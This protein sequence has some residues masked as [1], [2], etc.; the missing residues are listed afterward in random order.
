VEGLGSFNGRN[1]YGVHSDLRAIGGRSGFCD[2]VGV[3]AKGFDVV[4]KEVRGSG[5]RHKDE[6]GVQSDELLAE[7]FPPFETI[8]VTIDDVVKLIYKH[9]SKLLPCRRG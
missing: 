1:A 3:Q 9:F 7:G 2:F 8:G 4:V 5:G 6:H